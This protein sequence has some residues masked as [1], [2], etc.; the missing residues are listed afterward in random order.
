MLQIFERTLRMIY[1]PVNEN[2]TWKTGYNNEIYTFYNEPDIVKVAKT[3]RMKWLGH[4]FTSLE[5]KK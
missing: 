5:C 3:G 1:G 4:L 2:G